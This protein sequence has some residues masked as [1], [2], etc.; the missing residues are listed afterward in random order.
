MFEFHARP[1]NREEAKNQQNRK[2]NQR[3]PIYNIGEPA[4]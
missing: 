1:F 2:R 4:K 3:E